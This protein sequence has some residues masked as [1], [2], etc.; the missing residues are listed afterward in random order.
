MKLSLAL[1]R[2]L[3]HG[4]PQHDQERLFIYQ[5]EIHRA[6]AAVRVQTRFRRPLNAGTLSKLLGI[7][8]P[9]HTFPTKRSR[10][11]WQLSRCSWRPAQ[12]TGLGAGCGPLRGGCPEVTLSKTKNNAGSRDSLPRG[13]AF[14]RRL[15][16]LDLTPPSYRAPSCVRF[17]RASA[18]EWI[19]VFGAPRNTR[20]NFNGLQPQPFL[21][22]WSGEALFWQ[23]NRPFS[24]PSECRHGSIRPAG[25]CNWEML[26]GSADDPNMTWKM[27]V[28]EW[29]MC[30]H[31]SKS[32]K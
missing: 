8:C 9:F 3:L 28:G 15:R 30:R 25:R 1:Q 23:S 2:V 13:P 22:C 26:K 11:G 29:L 32:T 7:Q 4:R 5:T 31:A 10:C 12:H 17:R 18:S 14:W 27:L 24:T 19:S 21:C 16:P 20:L 6:H